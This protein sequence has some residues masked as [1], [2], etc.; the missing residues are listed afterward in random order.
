M[1][2]NTAG[3]TA[4][5]SVNQDIQYLRKRYTVPATTGTVS[6][7]NTTTTLGTIPAGSIILSAISGVDVNVVAN[8]GTNNRLNIGITGTTAKYASNSSLTALGFVAM[9]V[10]VGHR[11]TVDTPIIVTLDITGT[12]PTTGDFDVVVAYVKDNDFRGV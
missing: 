4:R 11:V 5:D 7:T 6:Y 1:A 3:S 2:T 8:A 12:T 9:A 10:A